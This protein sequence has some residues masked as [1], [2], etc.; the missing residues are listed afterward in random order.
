MVTINWGDGAPPLVVELP[1]DGF[2]FQAQHLY[3]EGLAPGLILPITVTVSDSDT[4]SATAGAAVTV[5]NVSPI[6]PPGALQLSGSTVPEGDAVTLAGSFVDPG[7]R[8]THRVLIDWGDGSAVE[9]RDLPEGARAF[10][11]IAHTYR[12]NGDY[13]VHVT[14]RDDDGGEATA[15]L[16]VRIT[17]VNP[18]AAILGPAEGLEGS[19]ITLAG[20]VSDP[21][22]DTHSYLWSVTRNGSAYASGEG[23]SF[24]FTPDDNRTYL[25]T[26]TVTD[27][28]GGVGAVT[29]T[30][31]VSNV[32]PTASI[33]G[34]PASSPE[35]T[36][37]TVGSTVTDPGALDT[38][39]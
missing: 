19:P 30:I 14:V 31:A 25:V 5:E 7:A 17:N 11:P 21:G 1:S 23:A 13:V 28:D 36:A 18:T 24:S 34:A 10:G 3:N 35:G 22:D 15:L 32:A 8:D 37:L 16:P 20:V 38:F 26:L 2:T 39:G 27:D 29:K 6:F 12:D 33:T 4:D 9:A